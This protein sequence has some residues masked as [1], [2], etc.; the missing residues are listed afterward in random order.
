MATPLTV[1]PPAPAAP[2]PDAANVASS[3]S[4]PQPPPIDPVAMQR[5]G[6][7][8]G[9]RFKQYESDR[10]IAEL[11]WER[12]ARQFLGIYDPEVE[13]SIASNR[14]KAYPKLTRVKCVS[15]LSRLMNLLFQA[16]DKNWTVSPSPVPDLDQEDL[17]TVL[18]QVMA[19]ANPQG[20][21]SADAIGQGQQPQQ[22]SDEVIEQAIREF[23]KKRAR[24]MELEIEDQLQELGG[25]R[26]LDYVA[27]CRKV[28]MSG[29]QYG[30]GVLKGPFVRE[31]KARRWEMSGDGKL[32]AVEYT[33]LRPLLEFVSLW[34]Y[35]PDMG[36]K[37]FNQ[38]DGQYERV[39]MSKHQVVELKSRSDFM[40]DQVAA[41]LRANPN[42]NYV[43][44]AFETELR[45]MGSQINT[46]NTEQKKYE[47]VVWTGFVSGIDLA[48]CGVLVPEE[49]LTEDVRAIIW[50]MGN[51][52]VKA[53][54]DPWSDL[55][56]E[57][58]MQMYHHFLFEEDE[59]F[60]LGNGLPSIMR[61]S[62]M[63][64]CAAVRMAL[65]NGAVQRVFEVNDA[66]LR[67]D[68]D[69]TVIN[70]DMIIHRDDDSPAT[71]QYPAIRPIEIPM[72]L[73]Q[74]QSLANMFQGFADQE[75]FVSAATGGDMS[76]GPSEPFRTAT[77]ASMLR[78]D[79]ALPFKDVVRNFDNF[80]QS[81]I[82]SLLVFNRHF[83]TN[84][85]IKGDFRPVPRGAT[86]LIAK[87]VLGIQLDNFAQT[88]TDGEK[89][90]VSMRNLVRERVS[91]RDLD[92][93]DI[94]YDDAKCDQIDADT[95]QQQQSA[96]QQQQDLFKAQLREI[97][98]GALKDLSQAGKNSAAAEATTANVIL[99]AM[100]KGL[101]PDQVSPN[102]LTGGNDGGA[103]S[104]AGGANAGGVGGGANSAA[105]AGGGGASQADQGEQGGTG[106]VV[107]PAA[108]A[109]AADPVGQQAAAM[110]AG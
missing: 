77:G 54:I 12:N 82:Y 40:A 86:S 46:S 45:A 108:L 37:T 94:V 103:N 36:A 95:A 93:E 14:S 84:P 42:G 57:G 73:E 67:L 52:V 102:Q 53:T 90:Y 75:T 6:V 31:V 38:M 32:T 74:M 100:Q 58:E 5:L 17:Q 2:T 23:A 60:L 59:S 97:L 47:A 91:V 92:V 69:L 39:V 51:Y 62:Q 71:A 105:A 41:F 70:P 106:A 56:H 8:L 26:M 80:T 64:L 35:Y 1:V 107:A 110:P 72:H 96:Q 76:K 79:A 15:M 16:D 48:A 63:G 109:A 104:S 9:S 55:G 87:E 13:R 3:V 101:N 43:R 21:P 65:D 44:R 7:E 30:A 19:A 10:R 66:L 78:G 49:R 88:L 18:D 61:D 68:Q 28:L 98:A 25:S 83:N 22:P 20:M 89:P 99:D 50:I 4:V 34:D 29:V 27:L 11:K 33:A 24:R 81:V 85:A